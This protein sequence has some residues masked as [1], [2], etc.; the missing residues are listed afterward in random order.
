MRSS[1][2]LLPAACAKQKRRY[3]GYSAGDFKVFK[4]DQQTHRHTDHANPSYALSACN[5]A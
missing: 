1:M 2:C 3:F 5:A 4:L